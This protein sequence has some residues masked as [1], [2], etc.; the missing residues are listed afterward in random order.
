ML[1]PC[2]TYD[3]LPEWQKKIIFAYPDIYLTPNKAIETRYVEGNHSFC[4]L[5]YGFEFDEGW[6]ELAES[7]SSVA[8]QL[9]KALRNSGIQPSAY[10]HAMVFKEKYGRLRWHGSLSLPEPF[11]ALFSSHVHQLTAK[12]VY[13]CEV[14]GH[15]GELRNMS[16]V[17]KTLCQPEYER[18]KSRFEPVGD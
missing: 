5:R 2:F 8:D 4:N 17:W 7:F 6:K 18:M 13:I 12:S 9:V 16:G 3:S 1:Q 11:K 15:P 10:I 14:T